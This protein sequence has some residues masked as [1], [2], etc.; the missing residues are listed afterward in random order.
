YGITPAQI[1]GHSDIA[2][3]RKTDPGPMFDWVRYQRL[4]QTQ[5][6]QGE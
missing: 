4:W 2:P 5:L 6:E 3:G 1:T